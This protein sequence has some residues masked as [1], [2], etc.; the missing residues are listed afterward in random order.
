[1]RGRN[2]NG[3]EFDLGMSNWIAPNSLIL[4]DVTLSK[5]VPLQNHF[6]LITQK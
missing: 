2:I 3:R 4:G 6:R 1:L 5:N